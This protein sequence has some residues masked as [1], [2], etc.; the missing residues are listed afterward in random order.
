MVCLLSY[1]IIISKQMNSSPEKEKLKG[2]M[3]LSDKG[4]FPSTRK[5][6]K[7]H[8]FRLTCMRNQADLTTV[9]A[10]ALSL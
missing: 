8:V 6:G 5:V 7:N 3:I 4:E 10:S 1:N 9:I 2:I